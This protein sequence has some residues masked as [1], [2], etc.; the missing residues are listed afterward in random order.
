M[1]QVEDPGPVVDGPSGEPGPEAASV[2]GEVKGRLLYTSSR[3]RDRQKSRMPSSACKYI[4]IS[5]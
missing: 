2:K 4:S 5:Q 1:E 3:L